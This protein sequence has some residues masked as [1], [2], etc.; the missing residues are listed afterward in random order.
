M[1]SLILTRDEVPI[2]EFY[3]DH[4]HEMDTSKMA[5]PQ[6]SAILKECPRFRILIIGKMGAG[7]STIC[8]LVFGLT[9]RAVRFG[10]SIPVCL[11]LTAFSGWGSALRWRNARHREGNYLWRE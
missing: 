4:R 10:R 3:N 6:T 11:L 9:E 7:K 1:S 2:Q 8:R 5:I